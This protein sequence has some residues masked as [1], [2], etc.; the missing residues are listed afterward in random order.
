MITDWDDAYANAAYI[1]DGERWPDAWVAPA[2]RWRET[3]GARALLDLSYGDAPRNRFDL[4][5]PEGAPRGL[6]VFIHGGYWLALDKSYW[7]HL[8]RGPLERGFAV[9]MP[10]YTLCPEARIGGIV[11]EVAA[12][13]A[14]AAARVEGPIFITGHSAGGHLAARMAALPSPLSPEI[15]ARIAHVVPISALADLRPLMRTEMNETLRIDDAEA[16]AESPALLAPLP[17][18][19]V[20]CWV[21]ADERPEFRR[22]SALLANVWTGLGIA[23]ALVEEP[24]R[25]HFDVIDGL[26]DPDHPLTRTLLG[27]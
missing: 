25:H 21:G 23:T 4:F 8:S 10:S 13:I 11:R 7:S 19:R 6:V 24:G 2:Q 12:A 3:C 16:A 27:E 5:L 20:T 1:A 14:A 22:Q 17:G 9:A 26:E 18:A 15:A